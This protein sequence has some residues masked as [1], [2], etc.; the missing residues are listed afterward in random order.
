MWVL[1]ISFLTKSARSPDV[2]L[3]EIKECSY[4]QFQ[5]LNW[6]RQGTWG[7]VP[8]LTTPAENKAV[9]LPTPPAHVRQVM[10]KLWLKFKSTRFASCLPDDNSKYMASNCGS[11]GFSSSVLRVRRGGNQCMAFTTAQNEF[12]SSPSSLWVP[13]TPPTVWWQHTPVMTLGQWTGPFGALLPLHP[14]KG[15]LGSSGARQWNPDT[16]CAWGHTVAGLAQD[17]SSSAVQW[18]SPGTDAAAHR[19]SWQCLQCR[20]WWCTTASTWRQEI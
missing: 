17:P 18:S 15:S 1:P 3:K 4:V 20:S 7:K 12:F 9:L 11:A 6:E 19:P 2:A 8:F 13:I 14:T 10:R 16:P 5:C